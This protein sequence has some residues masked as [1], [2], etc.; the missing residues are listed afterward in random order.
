VSV[1]HSSRSDSW[2][3]PP[4]ILYLAREVLGHIQLDPASSVEANCAVGATRIFT[5]ASDGLT[6]PWPTHP[7][8]V[9]LNPPGGKIG[10]RSKAALFWKRLMDYREAGH[11][12]HAIFLAFS[13][14]ALQTTQGKGCKPIAEFP[15]CVPAKRIAFVHSDDGA[16]KEAPSHSNMIVYVPGSVDRTEEFS[17]IFSSLGAVL[18]TQR[19]P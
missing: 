19:H 4:K 13:V 1:Q 2:Q 15:F 9:F 10:N 5:E 3:T 8:T 7:N 17:R 16:V 14:D 11:L 6:S 12:T 18:N